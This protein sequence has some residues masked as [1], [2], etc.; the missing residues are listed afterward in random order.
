[1]IAIGTLGAPGAH[2]DDDVLVRRLDGELDPG[3]PQA[4]EAHLATCLR[5]RGEYDELAQLSRRFSDAV[6]LVDAAPAWDSTRP[7]RR[8]RPAP[9]RFGSPVW[10]AA[11]ALAFVAGLALAITPV[12]AWIAERLG[13]RPDGPAAES[14]PPD[15]SAPAAIP[16]PSDIR[17]A[18]VPTGERFT[19]RVADRQATGALILSV[20]PSDTASGEI[21]GTGGA[22]LLVLPDGLGIR[23]AGTSTADYRVLVPRNLTRV[24]VVIGD[25]VLW[26]GSPDALTS[27][28]LAIDLTRLDASSDGGTND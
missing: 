23:N 13:I 28:V 12:R 9:H 19:I 11:A 17:I 5:C 20:A 24:V 15:A 22:D 7:A 3:E 14:A 1:V 8:F 6:P 27:G 26:Q 18:F 25:R 4:V 16:A 2:L 21:L 10:R